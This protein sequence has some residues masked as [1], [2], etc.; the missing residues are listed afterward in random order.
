MPFIGFEVMHVA[1]CASNTTHS[2]V[3][4]ELRGGD[5]VAMPVGNKAGYSASS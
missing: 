1:K 5:D 3:F 2:V 4:Q